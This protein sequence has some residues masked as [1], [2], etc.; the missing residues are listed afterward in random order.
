MIE[1]SR[2]A[3]AGEETA[4]HQRPSGTGL[5]DRG[6]A[7]GPVGTHSLD[8]PTYRSVGPRRRRLIDRLTVIM[9]RPPA[10]SAIV[11]VHIIGSVLLTLGLP[12]YRALAD[13]SLSQLTS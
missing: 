2:G 7:G 12:D 5:P 10:V 6:K 13:V 3:A 4:Q 8:L 9:Y 11:R 1:S